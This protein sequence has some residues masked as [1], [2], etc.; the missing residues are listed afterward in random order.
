MEE[1]V[2]LAVGETLFCC[3]GCMGGRFGKLI[4][5]ASASLSLS[6]T[7]GVSATRP[8]RGSCS[9]ESTVSTSLQNLLLRQLLCRRLDS[10]VSRPNNTDE[11]PSW[12][13]FWLSN[14]SPSVFWNSHVR[15]SSS[16]RIYPDCVRFCWWMSHVDC[17]TWLDSSFFRWC[18]VCTRS[19]HA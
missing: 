1:D 7:F 3:G 17:L 9:P 16:V 8:S 12:A 2:L 18:C 13:I 6:S 4:D 14:D 19:F 15:A 11:F 10:L 5:S